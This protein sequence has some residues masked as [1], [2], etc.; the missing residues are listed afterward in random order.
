MKTPKTRPRL[1]IPGR[2][3]QPT[4]QG[5]VDGDC[6]FASLPVKGGM[7]RSAGVEVPQWQLPAGF[8][9][10]AAYQFDW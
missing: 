10:E 9:T 5:P 8:N 7:Q 6:L 2:G 3:Q 4:A 1:V